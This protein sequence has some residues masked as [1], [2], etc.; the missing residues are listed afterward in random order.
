MKVRNRSFDFIAKALSF[1][2]SRC[3][4]VSLK[5]RSPQFASKLVVVFGGN[6][7]LQVSFFFAARIIDFDHYL[8]LV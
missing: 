6:F 4:S 7:E 8:Q 3:V 1:E 5:F 2:E